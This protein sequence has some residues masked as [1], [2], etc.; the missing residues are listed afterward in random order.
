MAVVLTVDQQHSRTGP[1]GVPALLTL[2]HAT[3]SE[4][5]LRPFQRTVGDEVQAVLD[6]ADTTVE[7]L[8]A[9][10]RTEGWS[11]G[12]GVGATELPLPVDARAGRGPAYLCAREAVTRA[13]SL[14]HRI[15]V[16][17]AD[18]YRA[19]H[20]ETALWLWAGILERR[21]ERGWQVHDALAEGLSHEEAA[22]RLGVTPS[23]VSQR[24]R[25]AGLTDERRARKL[26]RDL[27]DEM[28]VEGDRCP[29]SATTTSKE[30]R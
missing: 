19:E 5:P 9:I 15:G 10:L 16:V 17:G 18:R 6:R 28:I 12:V 13:K 21:T 23:A 26:V 29:S 3:P 4:R 7:L 1:D 24:A 8:A 27:L 2:L 20:V 25:A 22:R 14:P 11:V 30:S